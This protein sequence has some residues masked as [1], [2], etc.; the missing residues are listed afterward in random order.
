MTVRQSSR[1]KERECF[2]M[3][4]ART[5]IPRFSMMQFTCQFSAHGHYQ[6][7]TSLARIQ[8]LESPNK[9][10]HRSGKAPGLRSFLHSF[11]TA[12]D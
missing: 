3:R 4:D 12:P 11:H 5:R 6:W 2:P 8:P 10:F 1:I 9:I 7:V